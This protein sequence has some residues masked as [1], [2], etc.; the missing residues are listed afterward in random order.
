MN[1]PSSGSSSSKTTYLDIVALVAKT[2]FPK[3]PV[4]YNL[5][6]IKLVQDGVRILHNLTE[7]RIVLRRMTKK[8]TLLKLAVNMTTS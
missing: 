1:E 4:S 7:Y 2:T 5:V 6:D 3:E 8:Y